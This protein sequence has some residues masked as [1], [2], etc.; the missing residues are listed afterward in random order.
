MNLEDARYFHDT[1][2]KNGVIA[3]LQTSWGDSSFFSYGDDYLL[4]HSDFT[5]L[6]SCELSPK[7]PSTSSACLLVKQREL[8]VGASAASLLDWAYGGSVYDKDCDSKRNPS[9]CK[10]LPTAAVGSE[11]SFI[12]NQMR[13][14][15]RRADLPQSPP[16][17]SYQS[18]TFQKAFNK[19]NDILH[20]GVNLSLLSSLGSEASWLTSYNLSWNY[21]HAQNLGKNSF[22]FSYMF[23]WRWATR[24]LIGAAPYLELG[25]QYKNGV[26]KLYSGVGTK[27]GFS[28]LPEGWIRL[29][30]EFGVYV[31]TPL[32]LYD[33]EKIKTKSQE[34]SQIIEVSVGLAFL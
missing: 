25:E 29:P 30:L 15:I 14:R 7:T 26:R 10:Y 1:D 9:V 12:S 22:E 23:H 3:Y 32:N 2:S 13:K 33:P 17:F 34:N 6:S 8:I 5:N 28:I 20:L 18:L 11:P 24:F 27:V 4:S 31:K 16:A 21:A 19:N